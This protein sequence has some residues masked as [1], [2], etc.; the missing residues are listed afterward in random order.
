MS[1][2]NLVAI[3]ADSNYD[4]VLDERRTSPVAGCM[5][6]ASS[7]PRTEAAAVENCGRFSLNGNISGVFSFDFVLRA[8]ISPMYSACLIFRQAI[9]ME[10]VP[11]ITGLILGYKLNFI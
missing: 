6:T 10:E 11:K 5:A 2:I 8:W 3:R 4:S 9:K 7:K 1:N